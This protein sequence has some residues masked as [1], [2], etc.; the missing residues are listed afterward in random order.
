MSKLNER[1]ELKKC[2]ADKNKSNWSLLKKEFTE[3]SGK[4]PFL[5]ECLLDIF[6]NRLIQLGGNFSLAGCISDV[7]CEG[8]YRQLLRRFELGNRRFS[9]ILFRPKTEKDNE[10]L[11]EINYMYPLSSGFAEERDEMMRKFFLDIGITV[12]LIP[13]AKKIIENSVDLLVIFDYMDSPRLHREKMV[14]W[15]DEKI[16]EIQNNILKNDI[17]TKCK[18]ANV[19]L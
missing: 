7:Y 1:I 11:K 3:L 5:S 15:V 18:D 13:F 10:V 17:S 14:V 19:T 12:G 4:A 6:G 2:L 9:I 8:D 16:A